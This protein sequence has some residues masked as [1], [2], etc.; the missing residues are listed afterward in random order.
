MILDTNFAIHVERE[1]RR[2]IPGKAAAFVSGCPEE[3]FYITFTVAG[4]LAA[5]DSAKSQEVWQW[6]CAPYSILPWSREIAWQY[7]KIYKALKTR[8]MLIGSNDI[9]IAA[10][11]LAHNL[12]LVTNNVDEFQRVKGLKVLPY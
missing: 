8:G 2:G 11:A 6:L 9:W 1:K 12:P 7:G 3:T 10:T 4:E 5:G